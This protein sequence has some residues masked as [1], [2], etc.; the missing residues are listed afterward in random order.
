MRKLSWWLPCL[1]FLALL[2]SISFGSD[3]WCFLDRVPGDLLCSEPKPSS[4]GSR[5]IAMA[6]G[7]A[8]GVP[9]QLTR[10]SEGNLQ[11]R[12]IEQSGPTVQTGPLEI[13]IYRI[14]RIKGTDALGQG[15]EF[16]DVLLPPQ[17]KNTAEDGSV[18]FDMG[19]LAAGTHYFWLKAAS[20]SGASRGTRKLRLQVGDDPVEKI[21]P[22][23][24]VNLDLP[25]ELPVTVM[26][27]VYTMSSK[28]ERIARAGEILELLARYRINAASGILADTQVYSS[29]KVVE[30][31]YVNLVRTAFG[32]LGYKE[33]RLPKYTP[34]QDPCSPSDPLPAFEA[35]G[36]CLVEEGSPWGS[37]FQVHEEYLRSVLARLLEENPGWAGRFSYKWW[38][39]P[40][41]KDYPTV[42]CVYM[43][44][45]GFGLN[46]KQELTEQPCDDPCGE[47][48]VIGPW[49]D[50]N[51]WTLNYR[52]L[53]SQNVAMGKAAGA[54]V[55][56]YANRWHGL[57]P[58][59]Y[60]P[61]LAMA[62]RMIGWMIWYY[63]LDGYYLPGVNKPPV[64]DGTLDWEQIQW[65]DQES[66]NLED[67]SFLNQTLVYTATVGG[68]TRIV[69]SLRLEALRDGLED[70]LILKELEKRDDRAEFVAKMRAEVKGFHESAMDPT[71]NCCDNENIRY[72]KDLPPNMSYRHD[73]LL[74]VKWLEEFPTGTLTPIPEKSLGEGAVR[75]PMS[76]LTGKESGR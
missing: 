18:V 26:A 32:R 46:L 42:R 13:E 28:E 29:K 22:I 12:V 19:T 75:S 58:E 68:V 39:E 76:E 47:P 21:L 60:C 33:I 64:K 6:A 31:D 16:L 40:S 5:T 35:C 65:L 52:C 20:M 73:A 51:I 59:L 48:S 71:E 53:R 10:E 72:P 57:R 45:Q 50:V 15:H 4:R 38:D 34:S 44:L 66:G 41:M 9:F 49:P 24:V 63:G 43:T 70:L 55:R 2:P 61:S 54:E 37:C 11:V 69:P 3:S 74:Q 17:G 8:E 14:E 62:P 36:T 1:F 7:E 23:E 67:I 30:E 25:V 27:N 56:L